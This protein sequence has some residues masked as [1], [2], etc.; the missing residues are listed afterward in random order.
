MFDRIYGTDGSYEMAVF[1]AEGT[2]VQELEEKLSEAGYQIYREKS[3][4]EMETRLYE[5]WTFYDSID[6]E[7][8]IINQENYRDYLE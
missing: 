6:G 7:D 1:P 5:S 8:V 4:Y 2:D 3:W